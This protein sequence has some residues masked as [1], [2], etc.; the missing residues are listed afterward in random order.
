LIHLDPV[1]FTLIR[2]L[3]CS[4]ARRVRHP[5]TPPDLVETGL[6]HLDSVGFTLIRPLC[7]S[8][9]R[10]VR[11][12]ITPPDLAEIGL[13][14]L[15]SVGFTLIRPSHGTAS[16]RF[17]FLLSCLPHSVISRSF[18]CTSFGSFRSVTRRRP[19][20]VLP[21]NSTE[22]GLIYLDSVGF[23]LMRPVRCPPRRRFR[24]PVQH[25]QTVLRRP[26]P[27]KT[28]LIQRDSV[29][30]TVISPRGSRPLSKPAVRGFSVGSRIP[31]DVAPG[32]ASGH[33]PFHRA[34]KV[35]GAPH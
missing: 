11:H 35:R 20:S 1:G 17:W 15:D 12:P 31:P 27:T 10:R 18:H 2:P 25:Y 3:C 23:T 4:A 6:I 32:F 9:A 28:S 22:T 24:T 19:P 13:I 14:Y 8:A 7:C 34:P 5:I 16:R 26:N 21:P 30:F 33:S 29:G